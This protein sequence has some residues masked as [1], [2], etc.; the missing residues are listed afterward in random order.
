MT[1]ADY[2]ATP[3]EHLDITRFNP[4]PLVDGIGKT[5]FTARD[6]SRAADITARMM[7]D[8]DCGVVLC[9]AGS[10]ISAGLEEGHR[11]H[12]IRLQDG[13]C[14][15]QRPGANI[16]DQDFFEALGFRHY[17]AEEKRPKSGMHDGELR[18]LAHRPDLRHADRR[19]RT[20]SVRRRDAANHRRPRTAGAA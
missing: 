9:L 14:H 2:L 3:V 18:E 13:R 4:V 15:R 12:A 7:R 11:R 17:V 16:V 10:L 8:T 20:A 1:K 19:G 6:L 5:A